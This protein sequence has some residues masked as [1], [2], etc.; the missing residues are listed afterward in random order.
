LD[1][2]IYH[3]SKRWL[4]VF[5]LVIGAYV[6]LPVLAPVLMVVG[7]PRVSRVIYAA[8]RPACHQL[9]ER[10]FFLFGPQATYTQDELWALGL[11]SQADSGLSTS[12]TLL[13][14]LFLGTPE[15][16]YKIALCQ[17]DIALYGGLLL[18]GMVF[19]LVRKRLRPLSF[20]QYGL[21]LLPMV[22][23]GGTQL[24]LLRESNWLLRTLTGGLVGIASVWV[25]YPRLEAAFA[26][27]RSQADDRV[28]PTKGS[29]RKAEG[30][31][32]L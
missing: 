14:Q 3:L 19:G 8:Y 25:L 22:I 21:S 30:C 27:L 4:A 31:D 17:R 24:I 1:R 20:L 16:G 18:G 29:H 9:P 11:L 23:D 13:R 5:N 2:L 26:D 15:V 32:A 6:L 28:H 10:T 12:S 7:A